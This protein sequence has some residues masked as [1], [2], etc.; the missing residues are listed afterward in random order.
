MILL[1]TTNIRP[2]GEIYN[3]F[4]PQESN[5]SIPTCH[6]C[7]VLDTSIFWPL[8]SAYYVTYIQ[9]SSFKR[10]TAYQLLQSSNS[11]ERYA[12]KYSQDLKF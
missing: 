6:A 5:V 9:H 4:P 3:G 12:R 2:F 7:T 8:R 1:L 11:V 10:H